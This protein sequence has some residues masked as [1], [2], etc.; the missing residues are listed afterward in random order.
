MRYKSTKD[1]IFATHIYQKSIKIHEEISF[2]NRNVS[3]C[4]YRVRQLS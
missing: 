4:I 1:C 2:C 3:T